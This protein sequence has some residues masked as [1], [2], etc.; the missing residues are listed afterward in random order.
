MPA[1]SVFWSLLGRLATPEDK[2]PTVSLSAP[3]KVKVKK[4]AILS[5]NAADD[6]GVVNVTFYAGNRQALCG[7]PRAVL[8]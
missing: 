4:V 2:P 1:I 5:A 3:N 6:K 8:L 7:Y